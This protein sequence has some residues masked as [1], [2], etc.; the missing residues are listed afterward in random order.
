VQE[1]KRKDTKVLASQA[2]K[3]TFSNHYDIAINM[4]LKLV[5]SLI[6]PNFMYG[7]VLFSRAGTESFRRLQVAF[8]S[9]A[10]FVYGLRRYDHVSHISKMVLG[11]TLPCYYRFRACVYIFRLLK[12]G[13]PGYLAE[14]LQTGRSE[15]SVNLVLPPRVSELRAR[16]FFVD[17]PRT[18]NELP[19]VVKAMN[20]ESAFKA[21][22]F[23]FWSNR[24]DLY[25]FFLFLYLGF[26]Y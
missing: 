25:F 11:C 1:I 8:N 23:T 19:T 20:V 12:G 26:E 22:C 17:G 18:Y 5:R 3:Y 15:R 24:D 6:V 4:K 21:A 2:N 13:T 7:D 9:C 10:R 14:L 16:T